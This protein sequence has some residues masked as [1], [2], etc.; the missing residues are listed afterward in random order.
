MENTIFT[1]PF[2]FL[3]HILFLLP[4]TE[5]PFY[6]VIQATPRSTICKARVVPLRPRVFI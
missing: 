1:S 6:M 2:S 5:P 3:F 4:E